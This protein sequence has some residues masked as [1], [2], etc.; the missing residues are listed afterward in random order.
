MG[1]LLIFRASGEVAGAFKAT[2]PV[3]ALTEFYNANGWPPWVWINGK[4]IHYEVGNPQHLSADFQ[5]N[6]AAYALKGDE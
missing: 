2:T 4:P 1:I 3:D 5:D 6:W